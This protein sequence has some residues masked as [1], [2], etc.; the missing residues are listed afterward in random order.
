MAGPVFVRAG[1][2]QG[3]ASGANVNPA[4]PTVDGAAGILIAVV[5]SKNNTT[6]TTSTT[7][8]S[9]L[10]QVNSGANWTVSIFYAAESAGAPTFSFGATVA[11]HGQIF[12]YADPANSVDLVLT[13][14][15]SS[16]S[17][18]ATSTHTSTSINTTRDNS[19]VVY[20]DACSVST[21]LAT[22]AGWTENIDNG[23]ATSATRQGAGSK[24][25]ATSG[26]AS[27]A[28]SITAG[29]AAWVQYQLEIRGAAA[30]PLDASKVEE[31][32]WYEPAQDALSASKV[33]VGAWLVPNDNALKASKVE[34][35]VWLTLTPITPA[36]WKPRII[37]C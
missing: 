19:L 27:G 29:N 12:Y 25:V 35:G 30:G 14:S 23:S 22:P 26:S 2:L 7:G 4:K 21:A 6:H 28:I 18:G 24:S 1:A 36:T 8:W 3:T 20:L 33:E 37:M 32:V 13:S 31:G 11:G 16:S 34:Q 17:T 9:K 5:A 10:T 15:A